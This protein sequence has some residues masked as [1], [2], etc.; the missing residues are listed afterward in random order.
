MWPL[1]PPFDALFRKGAIFNDANPIHQG[2]RSTTMVFEFIVFGVGWAVLNGC[3]A[4]SLLLID[5]LRSALPTLP[6]PPSDLAVDNYAD[7]PASL[8]VL[9]VVVCLAGADRLRTTI[10]SPE[11]VSGSRSRGL[12]RS[13]VCIAVALLIVFGLSYLKD[14]LIATF[15]LRKDT[16]FQATMRSSDREAIVLGAFSSAPIFEELIFRGFL[17]SLIIALFP[18]ER[19]ILSTT[20]AAAIT[21]LGFIAFHVPQ[22]MTPSYDVDW[23]AISMVTLGTIVY[24]GVRIVSSSVLP[25]IAA[26]ATSNGLSLFS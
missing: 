23:V 26:H 21:G 4:S 14:S 8:I 11:S 13:V 10:V 6:T 16:H 1:P 3:I 22:Y 5:S 18:K 2:K 19:C 15:E 12:L 17:F 9:I 24:T 7:V 20:T 25:G